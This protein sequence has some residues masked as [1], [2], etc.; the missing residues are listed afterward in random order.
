MFFTKELKAELLDKLFV[1]SVLILINIA[2]A[3]YDN[4]FI[5]SKDKTKKPLPDV[6]QAMNDVPATIDDFGN[7]RELFEK[8]GADPNF[9]GPDDVSY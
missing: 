3:C 4:V 7:V 2:I 1:P 9:K 6:E 8:Y 5:Q